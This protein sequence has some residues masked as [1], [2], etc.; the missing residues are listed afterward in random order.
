MSD[1]KTDVDWNIQLDF[2]LP[3]KNKKEIPPPPPP[4]PRIAPREV[5][6]EKFPRI[7]EKVNSLWGTLELHKYFQQTQLMDRSGRQG[8]PD[9]V[10]AALGELNNE[11]MTL[12]QERG[13]LRMDAYD[14]QFRE[15]LRKR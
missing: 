11:H 1:E 5:L 2:E 10:V 3:E 9:E 8:F 14:L 4:P 12:L 6:R 13:M 15:V 7:L